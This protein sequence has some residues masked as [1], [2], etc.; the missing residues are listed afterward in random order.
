MVAKCILE[1]VH[2]FKLTHWV[3]GPIILLFRT[4]S[5]TKFT[6]H[7][8]YTKYTKYNCLHVDEDTKERGLVSLYL[9]IKNGQKWLKFP[10][11]VF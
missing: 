5:P 3:S 1:S 9:S 4:G 10:A 2:Y 8:K 7:T 11:A 6:K